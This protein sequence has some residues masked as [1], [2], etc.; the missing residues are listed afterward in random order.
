[1]V[2]VR[3]VISAVECESSKA[4]L[5]PYSTKQ[6]EEYWLTF[7]QQLR[8]YRLLRMLRMLLL[9]T[10]TMKCYTPI[11]ERVGMELGICEYREL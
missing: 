3:V 2:A 5:V 1:M 10:S 4:I 8:W 11:Y 9:D 6:N 7:S